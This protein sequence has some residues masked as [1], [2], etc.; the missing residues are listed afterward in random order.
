M[1]EQIKQMSIL[2]GFIILVISGLA[3][4]GRGNS[5]NDTPTASINNKLSGVLTL[6]ESKYDFRV[7]SMA[8]GKVNKEFILENQSNKDVQIGEVYTSCMCTVAELLVGNKFAGPFG[9]RGHGLASKAN[10]FVKPGEKLIVKAVFDPAAH[11][12][13]GIGPIEMEIALFT[14]AA[15]DPIILGFKAVVKP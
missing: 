12:P 2:L 15:K 11:G 7:V 1:K 9:M 8:S 3:W 13:A 6:K 5:K 10:L 14:S 4:F